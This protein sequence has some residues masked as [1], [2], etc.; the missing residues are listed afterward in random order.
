MPYYV[1]PY[2]LYYPVVNLVPKQ[3]RSACGAPRAWAQPIPVSP[4]GGGTRAVGYGRT[5]LVRAE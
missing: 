2:C 3:G 5:L 1:P 4:N